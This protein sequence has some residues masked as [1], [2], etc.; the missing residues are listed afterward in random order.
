MAWWIWLLIAYFGI[1]AVI[2]GHMI[3]DYVKWQICVLT[4]FFGVPLM[5]A[6]FCI[7]FFGGWWWR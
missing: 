6:Y 7:L 4:F 1:N 2:T 5:I 3:Y